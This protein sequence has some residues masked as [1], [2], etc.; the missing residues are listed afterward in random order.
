MGKER[1]TLKILKNLSFKRNLSLIYSKKL[2]LFLF[3]EILNY[4]GNLF[5]ACIIICAKNLHRHLFEFR[6]GKSLK[7]INS[8]LSVVAIY[9]K[10]LCI[11]ENKSTI[12]NVHFSSKIYSIFSRM[13]FWNILLAKNFSDVLNAL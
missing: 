13:T 8:I 2:N 9:K 5:F 12:D 11:P 4:T 7:N 6:E 10:S 3:S 1:A